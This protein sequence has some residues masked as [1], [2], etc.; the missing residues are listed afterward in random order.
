MLKTDRQIKAGNSDGL[1]FA[2]KRILNIDP[3][4]TI[5]ERP[6]SHCR[7]PEHVI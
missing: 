7:F 5:A 2:A 6:I 4:L 1:L 3:L